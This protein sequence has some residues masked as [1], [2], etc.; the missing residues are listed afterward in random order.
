MKKT[1]CSHSA[2]TAFAAAFPCTR[3]A[4]S[5]ACVVDTTTHPQTHTG[6]GANVRIFRE[7]GTN[8]LN[9]DQKS[10]RH[11][12]R[13]YGGA[14]FASWPQRRPA[15]A[16][17]APCLH[18]GGLC[19]RLRCRQ[20]RIAYAKMT[21]KN[22]SCIVEDKLA[23]RI[24]VKQ[25]TIYLQKKNPLKIFQLVVIVTQVMRKLRH[26]RRSGGGALA[27]KYF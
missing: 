23:T 11:A 7:R 13:I 18:A 8:T 22:Q 19:V 6:K 9:S 5:T 1:Q 14:L 25:C 16:H 27:V 2:A 20:L 26:V 12:L 3:V 21:K 24:L 10:S 17:Q 4:K 15:C